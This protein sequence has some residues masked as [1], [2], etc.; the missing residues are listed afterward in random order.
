CRAAARPMMRGRFGRIINIGSVTGVIGNPGQ[1]NYAAAKAGL[2]GLTKTLAKEL[3]GKGITANVV[4]PGFVDTDMVAELPPQALEEV[5]KRLPVRR[6]GQPEEIA[7][8]V[9]FLASD[10][11]GYVTGQVIVADGGLAG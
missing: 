11:A 5:V 8:V 10:L 6:L 1:A 7:H 4:A 9:S 3:G 2:I